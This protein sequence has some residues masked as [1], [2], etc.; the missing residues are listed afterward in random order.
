MLN[1]L[2]GF[3]NSKLAMVVVGIIIIPFVFW[4][5]GSVFSGGN[6]NNV[7][8][9]NNEAISTKDFVDHIN[10]SRLTNELIRENID[11]NILERVLSELVS[12]KL[13]DME[14][15]ELN[16][17]LSEKSL[18]AK[19]KSNRNFFDDKDNFSRIKYEKFLLENNLT[20]PNFETRLKKQELKRNL[21]NYI[22]GGVKSPYFL[23]NKYFISEQKKVELEYFDL[24]LAYSKDSSSSEINKFIEE[25]KE[26]LKEDYIDFS[27]AKIAPKDLVEIDEFN[28]EFFKK[29]DDIE[30]SI[31]NDLNINE[32]NKNY[33]FKIN[34]YKNYKNEKETDEILKLIYSKRNENK[35]QLIDKNE[36]FILF[37]I[38]K[39]NKI[40]PNKS[41]KKF[42]SIVK[43][44]LILKKK[45]EFNQKLY[46]KIED[47]K[48]NNEE[49][50]NIAKN[51][52]NIQS[53]TL[54]NIND[55]EIF[56]NDSIKLIYSLPKESF[57]LITGDKNKIFLA[58]VKNIYLDNLDKN[59]PKINEYFIKTNNTLIN[60]IY[61]T[62]DFSLNSKYKV[63]VFNETL[64]R[65]KNYF[66]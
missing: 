41:D 8:K 4:G 40:L 44:S 19:I 13:L 15:K 52:N 66:R 18:V 12:E 17:T 32:I 58:K 59:D 27:Y 35:I 61:N 25:N 54:K 16:V 62:Y 9:I 63:R 64:D 23:K 36:Y 7:A 47:K 3:S 26:L 30:N 28:D 22:S 57:V 24:D 39:I 21:F 33:N 60:D 65:V 6:T 34:S 51:T 2:R 11:K 45:Y 1:K 14:I 20:A 37:E 49:F 43:N 56:D 42:L 55:V 31:L 5:M 46:K 48:L 50:V 38:T 53:V 29:I 10:Q